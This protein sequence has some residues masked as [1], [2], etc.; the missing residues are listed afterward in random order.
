M[1]Y[2]STDQQDEINCP[3]CFEDTK[4]FYL[5]PCKHAWCQKCNLDPKFP[6]KCPLCRICCPLS[7]KSRRKVKRREAL[8]ATKEIL[9]FSL[10]NSNFGISV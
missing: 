2:Q 1:S 9:Y 5:S 6:R 3:V 7:P 10:A 8:K 4:D